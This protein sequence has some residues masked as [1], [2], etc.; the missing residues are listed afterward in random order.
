LDAELHDSR[1]TIK[2]LQSRFDAA[3]SSLNQLKI[4]FEN[5]LREK[6]EE[7]ENTRLAERA[8]PLISSFS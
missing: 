5:R 1:D 3:N 2:D 8:I 6:D 4:D 7:L